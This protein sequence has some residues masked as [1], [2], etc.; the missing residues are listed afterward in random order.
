MES[1]QL[2]HIIH[3]QEP[4]WGR[5]VLLEMLRNYSVPKNRYK[6]QALSLV[7]IALEQGVIPFADNSVATSQFIN[8]LRNLSR[9]TLE[10]SWPPIEIEVEKD[11]REYYQ[12]RERK[13]LGGGAMGC[14]LTGGSLYLIRAIG[15]GRPVPG[16]RGGRNNDYLRRAV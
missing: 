8:V 11:F 12:T 3:P 2:A 1:R 13:V 4:K 14:V 15:A 7:L 5:D 16:L 6:R 9:K 10:I